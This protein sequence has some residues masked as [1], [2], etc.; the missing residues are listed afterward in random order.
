M[1]SLSFFFKPNSLTLIDPL[2]LTDQAAAIASGLKT[3]LLLIW[4]RH[5][6]QFEAAIATSVWSC[7]AT[8]IWTHLNHDLKLQHHLSDTHLNHAADLKLAD[9]KLRRPP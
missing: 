7:R 5:H 1:F 9:L 3:P 4:S 2:T 6:R 8:S